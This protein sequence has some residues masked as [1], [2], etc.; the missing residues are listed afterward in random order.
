MKRTLLLLLVSMLALPLFAGGATEEVEPIEIVVLHGGGQPLT[1]QAWETTFA[2]AVD[3]WQAEYPE[4]TVA[5]R[6]IDLSDGSTMTMDALLAAGQ[7]P[8]IYDD[9]VG[10]VSKYLVPEFALDLSEH[11]DLSA[12]LDGVLTPYTRDGA[13][14]G[15]PRPG[16]AQGMAI[17]LEIM[18][19]IGYDP[20]FDWTI[21]DFL[22]MAALVRNHYDGEKFA[23]GM[24]A[25]NQSGDYL[26]NNWFAAFGVEKYADGYEYTTIDQGGA[27]VY[28]F[29]QHLVRQ[30]YVPPGAATLV[31]DDYVIQWAKGDLAAT[32][33]FPGWTKPY[34]DTVISQGLRDEP[35]DY[36]FLPFPH[37]KG[38]SGTPTYVSSAA[39]V[40]QNTGDARVDEAA[41]TFAGIYND[42]YVQT[43][44]ST[45]LLIPN[46][47][48]ATFL[49]DDPRVAETARIVAENGIMDVG[50][51]TPF[52]AAVRPQHYP[53]LQKV[54]NLDVTPEEGIAEYATRINDALSE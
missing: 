10:R 38:E 30:E 54:L 6:R 24:F 7:A 46:R 11:L 47:S 20:A 43:Q 15:L 13:V 41:A 37:L 26:I 45:N 36:K 2:Y 19:D 48:D 3:M 28:E 18:R 31:D 53:V 34:F 22:Q 27:Q 52:F 29:F 40:V 8:N 39:I 42:G 50:L 4:G 14:L 1:D 17:N 16:G 25:G 33:F 12:Y 23:T 44:M 32:A 35:F 5:E 21:K 49:P 51:T 9:Y